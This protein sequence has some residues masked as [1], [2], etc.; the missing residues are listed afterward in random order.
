[1]PIPSAPRDDAA[2]QVQPDLELEIDTTYGLPTGWGMDWATTVR[3]VLVGQLADPIIALSTFND[4]DIY[5]GHFTCCAPESGLIV[6]FVRL[7]EHPGTL[8]GF[9]AADGTIWKLISVKRS[10]SR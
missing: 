3:R 9:I 8:S 7:A 10:P 2:R 1:M 6:G 4:P 5:S